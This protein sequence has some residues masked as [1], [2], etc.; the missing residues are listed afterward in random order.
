MLWD[1]FNAFTNGIAQFKWN[2]FLGQWYTVA[3]I[4]FVLMNTYHR[5]FGFLIG[6]TVS[7]SFKQGVIMLFF[8]D[9]SYYCSNHSSHL[10]F[11]I[12]NLSLGV[13]QDKLSSN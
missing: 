2:M 8:L 11:A 12:G 6:P 4:W 10:V 13:S 5:L 9:H 7:S 3:I 1:H